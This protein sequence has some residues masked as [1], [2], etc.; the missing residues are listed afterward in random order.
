MYITCRERMRAHVPCVVLQHA[1][2]SDFW[3]ASCCG[4]GL[5]PVVGK[6]GRRGGVPGS[7]PTAVLDERETV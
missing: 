7:S 3:R 1:E 5:R 2:E 6:A 4:G